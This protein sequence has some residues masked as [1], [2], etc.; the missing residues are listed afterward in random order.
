MNVAAGWSHG[1]GGRLV[2]GWPAVAFILALE[3]LA[4]IVRRG[5]D[6]GDGRSPQAVPATPVVVA[7]RLQELVD[8]FGSQRAVERELK[9]PRD[10]LRKLI[11]PP[12]ELAAANGSGPHE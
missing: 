1:A 3:S 4:G 10:H 2:A 5:R 12:A 11:A 7:D 6:G 8:H 9:I